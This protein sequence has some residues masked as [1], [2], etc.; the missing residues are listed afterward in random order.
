MYSYGTFVAF[1]IA[2]LGL[3]LLTLR[4]QIQIKNMYHN[5]YV[6]H[7]KAFILATWVLIFITVSRAI[8]IITNWNLIDEFNYWQGFN[9]WSLTF[10][11]FILSVFQFLWFTGNKFNF[12]G[13]FRFKDY[14]IDL[15]RRKN[16]EEK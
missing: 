16:K 13:S 6:N 15:F 5:G 7:R 12:L 3:F 9:F 8:L 14:V 2:T 4:K 10:S 11:L 1:M